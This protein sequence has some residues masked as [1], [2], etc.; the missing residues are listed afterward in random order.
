LAAHGVNWDRLGAVSKRRSKGASFVIEDVAG[1]G[2][3]HIV[4]A[5]QN[6]DLPK[7]LKDDCR[8][9]DDFCLVGAIYDV[10]FDGHRKCEN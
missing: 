9:K 3:G 2:D 4:I 7:K 5:P 6:S 1:W 10:F 8:L